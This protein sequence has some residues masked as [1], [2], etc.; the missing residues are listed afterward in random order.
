MSI[1]NE[2]LAVTIRE[3]C[4]YSGLGRTKIYELIFSG[5]LETTTVGRRRLIRFPSLKA[6]IGGAPAEGA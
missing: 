1:N 5:A 4:R 3:G 2:P 6:L